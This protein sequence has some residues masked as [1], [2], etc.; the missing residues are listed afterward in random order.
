MHRILIVCLLVLMGANIFAANAVLDSLRHEIDTVSDDSVR[1]RSML[2]LADYL[3]HRDYRKSLEWLGKAE[4]TADQN[5]DEWAVARGKLLE[6]NIY[7][8]LGAG[9][10][11]AVLLYEALRSFQRFDDTLEL[12]RTHMAIGN[13]QGATEDHKLA[14]ASFQLAE[15]KY[16]SMGRMKGVANAQFSLAR[17]MSLINREQEALERYREVISVDSVVTPLL[18]A[19]TYNNIGNIYRKLGE[20]DSA[21]HYFEKALVVKREIGYGG[22]LANTYNN[23]AAT[24]LDRQSYDQALMYLDSAETL[25]LESGQIRFQIEHYGYR[26]QWAA[27]LGRF[28]LAYEYAEKRILLKDSFLDA[29]RA[30][31]ISELNA[32]YQTESQ[33]AQIDILSQEKAIADADQLHTRMI[34]FGLIGGVILLGIL[35][36][37]TILRFRE[38]TRATNELLAQG[39]EIERQK[40]EISS[41]NEE[42]QRKNQRL[43]E[44]NQEKDGLIGIVAHDIRAPLNRSAALA[45]LIA[46]VGPLTDEQRK[47]V[48][49]IGKVSE[50]G[51]R[52]IQ[53]LLELNAYER[54]DA[55][56]ERNT[57]DANEVL[58]HAAHGFAT[59]AERKNLQIHVATL[60]HKCPIVTDEKLLIRVLDNLISNAVK[61]THSG[62]NIYL[63]LRQD[64]RQVVFLIQ[65]EGQGISEEDRKK[66]FRKF[67]RLSARPTGGESSTGLGLSIVKTLVERL[68]GQLALQS[69]VGVGTTFTVAIPISAES[70]PIPK[71]DPAPALG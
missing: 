29:K 13:L 56:I 59:K 51:G 41:Q 62:K 55:R 4:K 3:S 69:E 52:L 23:L 5:N 12:A 24:Y 54:R 68:K 11:A 7:D 15:L 2:V 48:D 43:E 44:L 49:M 37:A 58:Q 50:D 67:Q 22:S 60:S 8:R 6:G 20:G 36:V 34:I 30:R 38:R 71:G 57:V 46:S 31:S 35:F 21:I 14:M 17:V 61:F 27:A 42:L 32:A 10:R 39:L 70:T 66:M 28:D 16:R 1:V 33:Q 9:D 40:T 63:K 26:S 45:E 47:F 64:D 53:D 18:R 65:D 25:A 19:A